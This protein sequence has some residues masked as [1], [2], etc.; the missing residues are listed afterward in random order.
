[1]KLTLKAVPVH[2]GLN[3]DHI[4]YLSSMMFADITRLLEDGHLYVPNEQDLEDFA[5]RQPNPSRISA[6]AKYILDHYQD[7]RVFFPPICINVQPAPSYIEGNL[8]IPYHSIT[9]RLTDGQHRCFGISKAL[10]N[11]KG[12]GNPCSEWHLLSQL[13]IGV[14]LYSGL[15][16]DDE[17][18]AFR[19]QNLLVQKPSV[20]LSHYFD[21]TS[22]FV[23]IAKDLMKRVPQFRNNVE[24]VANTLGKQNPKLLTLSTLVT[25]TKYMFPNIKS[26]ENLELITDWA[27][28]FWAAVASQLPNNPWKV[29]SQPQRQKQRDNSLVVSG[30][31]FQAL[32]ILGHDFYQQGTPTANL[33]KWLEKLSKINWEKNNNLWKEKGVT[34]IGNREGLIVP[35]TKTTVQNC[36]KV[37]KE[38][39]GAAPIIHLIE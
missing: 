3:T 7:G 13:E 36:Y 17:R 6:I 19:D 28:T 1:M 8:L 2:R 16:L 27:A 35:N 12:K 15:S 34:Q 4:S 38:F 29:T 37:L 39:T 24:T 22:S 11:V 31:V 18:Q 21:Q 32:G 20:S 5:Q 10:S 23:L 14:L 33:V 30:V 26:Q 9:L 25:A